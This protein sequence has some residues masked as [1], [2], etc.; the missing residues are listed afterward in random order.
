MLDADEIE[1]IVMAHYDDVLAYCRRH[2]PRGI[3]PHDLAQEVFLRFVRNAARYADVGKPHAYLVTIARNL[4]IDATRAHREVPTPFEHGERT[5]GGTEPHATA[6][7][8]TADVELELV[9]EKLPAELRDVLELRYDQTLGMSQI[10]GVLGISRFAV[11]RRLTRAL[12]LLRGELTADERDGAEGAL[13]R[14]REEEGRP[15]Q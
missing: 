9:L 5:Q 1:R 13:G 3:D 10:A 15:G 4:C 2:A 11:R 6:E 7:D 12:A 14:A 8:G